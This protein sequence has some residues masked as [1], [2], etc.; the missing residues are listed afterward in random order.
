VNVVNEVTLSGKKHHWEEY[1]FSW[2]NGVEGDY[3]H[4][5][6]HGLKGEMYDNFIRLGNLKEV[7]MS[8]QRV[9]ESGGNYYLLYTKV[10]APYDG[11]FNMMTGNIKP[12]LLFI[13]N[14]KTDINSTSIS[15]TKGANKVLLVYNKACETYFILRDPVV[16]RTQSQPVSMSWYRDNGVL[17]FDCSVTSN[18]SGLFAFESAPGLKSFTFSAYGKVT[19]WVDGIMNDLTSLNK[20]PDSLTNYIV[21]IKDSKYAG[22]LVALGIVYQPGY[23]GAAALPQYINQKCGKGSITLGDW[24]KIDGLKAY[25]G[26][27]W[28]RQNIFI[29]AQDINKKLEIDFVDL[30]SSAELFVNGKSNGLKV[31]PPWK[32]DIT[33]FIKQG[34]NQIEILIYNTLA[35]NYTSI[36]TRYRGNLKSGLIGPVILSMSNKP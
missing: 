21:N 14:S 24:S 13:N 30:V 16:R 12:F 32:F 19:V 2:Q 9:P 3:G 10:I 33:R 17:P 7:K 8:L 36:P 35:N 31:S 11:N 29:E 20:L 5:G 1:A 25:S 6:Y 15:L 34:D 18:S 4:Q 28:Y 23:S 22:S 26:G 27:A